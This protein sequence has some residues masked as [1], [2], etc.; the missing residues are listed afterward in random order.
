MCSNQPK[1]PATREGITFRPLNTADREPLLA[2]AARIWEGEDYL[3]HVFDSWV[4]EPD[5]PFIGI[6]LE[7]KLVG[8]GRLTP[9][10]AEQ[11]W[12]EALRVDPDLQGKG[13]GMALSRHMFALARDLRLQVLFYSTYYANSASIRIGE[14]AGFHKIADYSFLQCELGRGPAETGE[15]VSSTERRVDAARLTPGMTLP[16]RSMWND[17]FFVPP[18]VPH[19]E[20]YFPEARTL[21][22]GECTF[23]LAANRKD[24]RCILNV[25]WVDG[26]DRPGVETCIARTQEEARRSGRNSVEL[27]LPGRYEITPFVQAGFKSYER[28]RDVYLYSIRT[29][30]LKI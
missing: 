30:D 11:G 2:I 7:R 15:A 12:L 29:A 21:T 28:P 27:M 24:P 6:F 25:C 4:R 8:C 16:C 19:R 9:F 17:W 5:A 20:R 22:C 14:A 13:L 23:V 10:D 1:P 26:A 18:D 3:E